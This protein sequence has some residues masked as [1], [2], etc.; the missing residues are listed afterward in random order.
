VYAVFEDGTRWT[1][2][3]TLA[4]AERVAAGL[5]GLGARPGDMVVSWLPNG[6]DALRV[7]F[8]VNLLGCTLVPLNT[9]YRGGLLEHAIRLSGARVAVVHAELAGRLDEIDTGALER[10]VVLGADD[11]RPGRPVAA[12]R[13]EVLGPE[14]LATPAPGFRPESPHAPW[15]PYAVILT[16]GTTGSSKGVLCSYVQFA[17]CTRADLGG[18]FGADDRYMLNIP[19]FHAG[20][21]IGTYAALLLGGG[22]SLVSAFDTGSFWPTV[23]ATGTTHVT[24][25]G[26]MAT[27]LAK[28]P[29]SHQDR[30]HPLRH[31]FM[32]PL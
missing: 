10:V 22:I 29:P 28:R 32:I 9:A 1:Y 7:W 24:L 15:D 31:V 25:L 30:A 26:V 23:R 11:A 6:P 8:G 16:T 2:A 14:T 17:A 4:E 19:L 27:F 18:C 13:P 3:D 21:T 5:H 20:G 12:P